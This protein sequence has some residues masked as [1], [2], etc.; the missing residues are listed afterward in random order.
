MDDQVVIEQTHHVQLDPISSPVHGPVSLPIQDWPL[1]NL[2]HSFDS[3]KRNQQDHVGSFFTLSL[4]LRTSMAA[5]TG[6]QLHGYSAMAIT[7]YYRID[8]A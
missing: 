1:L 7:H 5:S 4:T 3:T 8:F 6:K 2:L